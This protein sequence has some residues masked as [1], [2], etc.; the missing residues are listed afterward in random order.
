[1]SSEFEDLWHAFI[2]RVKPL[3]TT[4]PYFAQKL[5]PPNKPTQIKV[6]EPP[7]TQPK[8][9]LKELVQ[10]DKANIDKNLCRKMD[11]GKLKIDAVLD[12]HGFTRNDA[13]ALLKNFINTAHAQGKRLL[14]I[15]TGKGGKSEYNLS[16]LKQELPHWL[17]DQSIRDK[18]LRFTLAH[19]SHGGAGAFYLLLKREREK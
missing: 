16:V 17:N 12:L 18:I 13:F 19:K 14:L 10:G 8:V 6:K 9:Q 2:K 4:K 11:S 1:M 7:K 5:K 3:E 15:I